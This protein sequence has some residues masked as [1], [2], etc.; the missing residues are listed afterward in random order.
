M[1]NSQT[2]R[3]GLLE[4][5]QTFNGGQ[6][7]HALFTTFNF[8][9]GFFE[10]NVLPL[11]C[12]LSLDDVQS[13][14]IEALAREMYHPLKN[15][16]V[17]VAYD[18]SVLQ[19]FQGRF[20]YSLLPRYQKGGFFHAKIIVLT[21]VDAQQKPSATV[22]VSSGNLTI[23]GWGSNIEVAAWAPV[24][25]ANA[26][27][28]LGFYKYLDDPELNIGKTILEDVKSEI[29]GPELFLHYPPSAPANPNTLFNRLFKPRLLGNVHIFSPYWGEDAIQSFQSKG[30]MH[31]YP[32]KEK[33]GYQ[34]PMNADRAKELGVFVQAI[35]GEESFRHAKAYCWNGFM[36]IGSANC[37]SQALHS[38]NNVEAM[39]L[40]SEQLQPNILTRSAPL[41]EWLLESS[42]EEGPEPIPVGVLVIA[43]YA[44]RSYQV[45]IDVSNSGRCATWQLMIGD[46]RLNGSADLEREIPFGN[47]KTIAQVYRIDWQGSADSK[48]LMGMIIPKNGSDVEL[49]YRPKRNMDQILRDMLRHKASKA[50]A[51]GG[52]LPPGIDDDQDLDGDEPELAPE[53]DDYDFDMYGMYQSF[54]H[55]RKDLDKANDSANLSWMYDEI[56]DTLQEIILIIQ[57]GEVQHPVQQWLLLQEAM[58]IAKQLPD[59]LSK[60]FAPYDGLQAELNQQVLNTL[61]SGSMMNYKIEP[62]ALLDWMRKELGYDR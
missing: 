24:N 48:S 53:A 15:M 39:M 25:Q 41:K 35:Q 13:M 43:D 50:R 52:V 4:M 23:S 55:L 16:Q 45:S 7:K 36:A 6:I 46:K 44:K 5:V 38:Q 31:C 19:G 59:I 47:A 3:E 60:K 54:Y 11:L 33:H 17:V 29:A 37:T 10:K 8:D 9:P 57:N 34:F 56:S 28:L 42:S 21:G 14:S 20:R 12:G 58:D 30:V 2:M 62:K 61:K 49:G 51:G 32:A 18:Q 26:K 40:F 27:E 22:M 1:S